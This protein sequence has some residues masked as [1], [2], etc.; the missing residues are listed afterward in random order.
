M[1][2]DCGTRGSH[3]RPRTDPSLA[4]ALALLKK[5]FSDCSRF[6]CVSQCSIAPYDPAATRRVPMFPK[7]V[8]HLQMDGIRIEHR[9]QTTA[10]VG[11][12]EVELN[13]LVM[14]LTSPA[15]IEIS[16]TSG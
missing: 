12:H 13:H 3:E 15:T 14:Q 11:A 8:C 9:A 2:Q 1:M 4:V 10:L 7:P 5:N 16:S 6:G